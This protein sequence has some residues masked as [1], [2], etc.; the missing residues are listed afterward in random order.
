MDYELFENGKIGNSFRSPT[1]TLAF[2]GPA[3]EPPVQKSLLAF[4]IVPKCLRI[5]TFF[6]GGGRTHAVALSS[7]L[8]TT[9][10]ALILLSATFSGTTIGRLSTMSAAAAARI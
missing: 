7:P 10:S 5:Q 2:L 4:S 1:T 8:L 9:S 6:L 3:A